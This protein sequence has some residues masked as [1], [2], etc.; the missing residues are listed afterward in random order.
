MCVYC[1][2]AHSNIKNIVFQISILKNVLLQSPLFHPREKERHKET[3]STQDVS[4]KIGLD[5][6]QDV[7]GN[8]PSRRDCLSKPAPNNSLY[9]LQMCNHHEMI[10]YVGLEISSV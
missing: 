8:M 1:P 5:G 3:L 4:N 2:A 7:I 6:D 9:T 10:D